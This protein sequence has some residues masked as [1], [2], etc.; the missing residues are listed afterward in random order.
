MAEEACSPCDGQEAAER[1]G[2][3]GIHGKGGLFAP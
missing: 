1:D 2:Q 3:M